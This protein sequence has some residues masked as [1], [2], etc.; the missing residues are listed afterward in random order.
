MRLAVDARE[1][2]GHPTGVGR[3]LA[4]LLEAWPKSDELLLVARRPLALPTMAARH[5]TILHP[6]PVPLPG[7]LW[8]QLILPDVVA[9]AG[10]QLLISPAYGMPWNA[11]CPVAVGM[12]DCA[13]FTLAE[14][15]RVR[16]RMRRQ[17]LARLAARRAALLFMGS[18]FAAAEAERHLGVDRQRV[19]VLPYGVSPRFRPP[20]DDE[21]ERI[22]RRYGMHGRTVLF[23]G[24]HLQRRMLPALAAAVERLARARP[25]VRLALVGRRPDAEQ[26]PGIDLPPDRLLWLGWVED[27]DLP[28]LYAAATVVAYPSTYEGFGLPVLEGLACGTPVVT[29]EAGSLAEIY[30]GRAWLV[31]NERPEEWE[32]ALATLLDS[33]EER[34]RR[35]RPA[36]DWAW[37][38]DW[39]AAASL[40]RDRISRIVEEAG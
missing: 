3:V 15:F 14:E 25:D 38:R 5:S 4:G 32:R 34:E 10:A 39:G 36:R 33:A 22:A 6:G 13:C 9:R 40:L 17:W 11:P 2:E 29:S 26:I 35:S 31:P 28:A 16:E 1:L 27:E 37:G 18:E 24:A 12:H 8:E 23:V 30:P 20:G 19:L 7:S 21:V